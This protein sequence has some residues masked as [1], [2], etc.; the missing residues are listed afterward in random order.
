MNKQE[1]DDKKADDSLLLTQSEMAELL[2]ISDRQQSRLERE[3]FQKIRLELE[4]RGFSAA[5]AEDLLMALRSG[6]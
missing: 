5:D 2:G 1:R 4:K 6:G 3:L